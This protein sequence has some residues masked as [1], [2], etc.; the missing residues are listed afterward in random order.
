MDNEEASEIFDALRGEKPEAPTS[1][2]EAQQLASATFTT[3]WGRIKFSFGSVEEAFFVRLLRF[4][5]EGGRQAETS[6]D[7][8][9]YAYEPAI[10]FYLARWFHEAKT[11]CNSTTSNLRSLPQLA[12]PEFWYLQLQT[13]AVLTAKITAFP[14]DKAGQRN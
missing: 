12:K 5:L 11:A 8:T 1:P 6:H 3:A 9:S 4:I 7:T 10:A 14:R 2:Y 13:A